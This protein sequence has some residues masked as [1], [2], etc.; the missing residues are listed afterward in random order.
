MAMKA[1]TFNGPH[2][3]DHSVSCF[4]F[5]ATGTASHFLAQYLAAALL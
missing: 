3:P 5:Q 2:L 4:V 1:L